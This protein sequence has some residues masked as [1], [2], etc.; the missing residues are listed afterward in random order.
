MTSRVGVVALAV[1]ACVGCKY[2][3]LPQR[4]APA[5]IAPAIDPPT[6]PPPTDS[7]GIYVD[8]EDGTSTVA[9][10]TKIEQEEQI[11]PSA[12]VIMMGTVP[13][14]VPTTV[15]VDVEKRSADVLCTT[16]CWIDLP[17]GKSHLISIT[18][19]HRKQSDIVSLAP[20]QQPSA[21]RHALGRHDQLDVGK[22]LPAAL[23][24]GLGVGFLVTLPLLA[25]ADPGTGVLLGWGIGGAAA[26]VLGGFMVYNSRAIQQDGAGVSYALPPATATH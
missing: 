7:G 18:G 6:S 12:S 15:T 9:R 22:R 3:Q 26:T 8:V 23:V 2:Q 21:Y 5:Q 14:V 13:V 1:V 24:L 20:K 16:P 11:R 4:A 17:L 19:L 10:I 25:L